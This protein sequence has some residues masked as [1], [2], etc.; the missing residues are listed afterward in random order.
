[1]STTILRTWV[2][3]APERTE[4]SQEL[5]ACILGLWGAS[6]CLKRPVAL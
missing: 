2:D 5:V 1:M 4:H 3:T 6:Q